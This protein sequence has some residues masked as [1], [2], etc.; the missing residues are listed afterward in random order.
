[1]KFLKKRVMHHHITVTDISIGVPPG[2]I[3][4]LPSSG[5]TFG[6]AITNHRQLAAINFTGSVPTFQYLWLKV[7]ENMNKYQSFPRLVGG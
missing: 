7:A 3:S 6:D 2:L 4:F 5:Q 1:M